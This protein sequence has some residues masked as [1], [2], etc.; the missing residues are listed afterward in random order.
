MGIHNMSTKPHKDLNQSAF[1]I[2]QQATGEE[3]KP[4]S[5]TD[6]RAAGGLARMAGLSSLEKTKLAKSAVD[7][8]AKKQQA[9]TLA[10]QPVKKHHISV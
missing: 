6:R 10:V 2:V 9:S 8:K 3:E 1:S 4:P 5:K 7:A